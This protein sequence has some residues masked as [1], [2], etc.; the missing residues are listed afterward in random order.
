MLVRF[1][2]REPRLCKIEHHKDDLPVY[3][4]QSMTPSQMYEMAKLG[5]PMSAGMVTDDMFEE[6]SSDVTFELSLPYRRG[7]EVNDVWNAF[8]SSRRSHV[9]KGKDYMTKIKEKQRLEQSKGGE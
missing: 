5:K 9:K 3:E 7:V 8:E 1:L 2:K 6:G 4:N